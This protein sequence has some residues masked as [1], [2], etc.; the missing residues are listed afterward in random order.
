MPEHAAGYNQETEELR[1]LYAYPLTQFMKDNDI[2]V[3]ADG[4]VEFTAQNKK[5]FI[6]FSIKWHSDEIKRNLEHMDRYERGANGVCLKLFQH[7]AKELVKIF[8]S[9]P[10]FLD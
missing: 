10:L 2:A 8:N 9:A 7:H 5:D 4:V 1:Q 6:K 3:P